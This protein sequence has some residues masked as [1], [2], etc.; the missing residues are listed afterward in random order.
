MSSG[1]KA[2]GPRF[3]Q[4]LIVAVLGG[5]ALRV[6]AWRELESMRDPAVDSDV[7]VASLIPGLTAADGAA[8]VE[9]VHG[10]GWVLLRYPHSDDVAN[11]RAQA[12]AALRGALGDE[13]PAVRAAVAFVLGNRLDAGRAA[14]DELRKAARNDKDDAVKLAAATALLKLGGENK[15]LALRT[16]AGLLA[17]PTAI[18]NRRVVIAAMVSTG[19][20]G[21]DEA[22]KGLVALLSDPDEDIRLEA[23]DCLTA[24]GSAARR[25]VPDLERMLT[26]GDLG[27]SYTAVLATMQMTGPDQP[28]DPRVRSVLERAVADTSRTL[29][30]R[31]EALEMLKNLAPEALRSCGLELARQLNHDDRDL[32][33]GAATLLQM[34][35]PE[36]LAGKNVPAQGRRQPGVPY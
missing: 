15:A 19:E 36:W 24:L 9:A 34:I 22:I 20:A 6:E 29:N 25:I 35:D 11:S 18:L 30:Q 3:Y 2:F 5:G 16:L 31:R 8:R 13:D 23:V 17:D 27:L 26:S 14:T 10:L 21:E 33:L 4:F 7:T 32:R 28:L 12:V 1:R